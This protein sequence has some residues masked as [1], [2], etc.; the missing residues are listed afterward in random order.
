M[1]P[2]EAVVPVMSLK[3]SHPFGVKLIPTHS[4]RPQQT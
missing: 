4:L 3:Y 2:W 1:L